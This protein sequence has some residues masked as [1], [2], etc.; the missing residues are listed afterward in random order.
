MF[1]SIASGK[2][3]KPKRVASLS[4]EIGN[5]QKGGAEESQDS[6]PE[7]SK[8]PRAKNITDLGTWKITRYYTPVKGQTKYF[9]GSYSKDFYINCQG[10]CLVTANGYR[11]KEEDEFKVVA[12]PP[13]IKF[14]TRL[15]IESIGEVICHDR[16]GAIKGKRLDLWA[17]IGQKGLDN[18]YSRPE[19]SGYHKVTLIQ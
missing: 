16:G 18:I 1:F 10:D 13:T 8:Q 15:Q 4:F 17:G 2:A 14:G 6:T 19:T 5:F 7:L 11:L 12:C 9:S 3:D